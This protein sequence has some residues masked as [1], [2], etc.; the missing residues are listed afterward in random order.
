M[1]IIKIDWE[2]LR[3]GETVMCPQCKEGVLTSPYDYKTSHFFECD[4]CG[5]KINCD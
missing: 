2:K 3:N 1:E 4:K 5:L